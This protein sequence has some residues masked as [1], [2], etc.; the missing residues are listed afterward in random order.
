[1]A[2]AAGAAAVCSWRTGVTLA[3]GRARW[4]PLTTT[5]SSAEQAAFD[6][7]H[8]PLARS[9][10]DRP[11]LDDAVV[12]DDEDVAAGLVRAQGELRNQQRVRALADRYADADEGARQQRAV[13]VGEDRPDLQRTVF[14]SMPLATKSTWPECG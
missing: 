11:L 14:G 2:A 8:G 13:G 7:L 3:P 4:M 1:M 6:D 9:G 5:Q 12:V 10:R